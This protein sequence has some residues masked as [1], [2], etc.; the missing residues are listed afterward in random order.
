METDDE[1]AVAV[2]DGAP[3]AVAAVVGGGGPPLR[4]EVKALDSALLK[5]WGGG[6]QAN[7][8]DGGPEQEGRLTVDAELQSRDTSHTQSHTVQWS[9]SYVNDPGEA[10]AFT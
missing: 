9:P 8:G 7:W 5:V 4:D 2:S 10:L 3:A 1:V 6:A